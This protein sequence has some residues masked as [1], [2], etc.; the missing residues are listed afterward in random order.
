MTRLALA[1]AVAVEH[2]PA[3]AI[4][5]PEAPPE[6]VP[7][8][9]VGDPEVDPVPDEAP[10]DASVTF[11]ASPAPPPPPHAARAV[12][13]SHAPAASQRRR[14]KGGYARAPGLRGR[15][16]DVRLIART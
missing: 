16:E 12:A 4:G 7:P 8:G 2:E 13:T 9:G 15:R 3:V 6:L 10:L 11:D 5:V 1:L 14:T